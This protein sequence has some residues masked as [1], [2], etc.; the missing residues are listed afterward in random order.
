MNVADTNLSYRWAIVF[1]S[2][3]ILAVSMGAIVNGISA[4]VVPM[5]EAYGWQ[6]GDVAFINFSGIMGMAL[7]G[8]VMGPQADRRGARP[9]VVFGSVV[10]GLCYLAASAV[11]EL[12]QLY[13]LFFLGGFFGAAAIFSPVM[14]TVGNWFIAGAG[15]AIGIVSA[16]QALGQG[17][18]PFVSALL[19]EAIGIRGAL[20][21]TGAVMLAVLLPLATMLRPAP[22]PQP[23]AGPAGTAADESY[24]PTNVVIA[25]LSAAIILCCTC[26]SVPLMHLVP[27]IQ[28]RGFSPT[29]PAA[30]SSSCCSWRSAEG[31]PS[32]CSPTA[33]GRCRPT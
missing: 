26:M 21:A 18:V 28:D 6:R 3:L 31:W 33:S 32:A 27:L 13:L 17:G 1:A 4:F 2:A 14:A 8:M 9:V 11:T 22:A 23:H 10:L 20:A 19:I 29:R 5:Q 25:T 12:W 15:T 24:L 16:G 7:G 30:S